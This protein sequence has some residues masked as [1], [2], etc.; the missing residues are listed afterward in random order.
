M[1]D[2]GWERYDSVAEEYRRVWH[3]NFEP[4]A[5]DLVELTAVTELPDN[6]A[7]L[8]VGMGTGVVAI[9]AARHV[10]RGVVVGI[11]PSVPM[12]SLA[13]TSAPL[14]P[15]AAECPGLPFPADT[16]HAV[17]GGFVLSHFEQYDTALADMVRV[18]RPG[19]RL[20]VTAWGTLDDEPV[21]DDQQREF[22]GIWKSVARRFVDVDAATEVVDAAIPWEGW[23]GDPAHLRA[24]LES[25][26]LRSVALHARVYRADVT[27]RDMLT[28]FETSFWGRYLHHALDDAAWQRFV[29]DV[30]ETT[31]TALPDPI[32][33]VDQLSIAVGAKPFGTRP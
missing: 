5:R 29:H 8:D 24:T 12:L 20:G 23:F 17:F 32:A 7:V 3:R 11:D 14:E 22:S 1:A 9:E 15:V 4:A 21:D 6:A 2:R 26:G 16:F 10:R 27:Q 30:A 33:R 18:L 28:G 13:R 19:G 25:G 31:R